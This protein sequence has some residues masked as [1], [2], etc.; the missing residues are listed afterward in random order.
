MVAMALRRI[1]VSDILSFS[2]SRYVVRHEVR[3]LRTLEEE[4]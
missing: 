3:E 2:R 4:A 1:L